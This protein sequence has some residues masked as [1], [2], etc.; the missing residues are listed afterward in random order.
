LHGRQG[1]RGKQRE[2][3]FCHVLWVPGKFARKCETPAINEQALGRIVAGLKRER[4]FISAPT[5]LESAA[6]HG[7]F[8]RSF[9]T[10]RLNQWRGTFAHQMLVGAGGVD[11]SGGP[12]IGN[13][14][15]RSPGNSSGCGG[16]PGSCTGGGISGRG[17][18]GGSS[19][20]GSVGCPGW[21]GGSSGG[22]IGIV[23]L[24][25]KS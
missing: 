16:S 23:L 12:G 9:Q 7:V 14:S 17:F 21:I 1:G 11:G 10:G 6:V 4:G 8:R 18:P 2:L 15:G 5:Q 19:R 22:S 24:L 25:P 13:S 20:G 3:S